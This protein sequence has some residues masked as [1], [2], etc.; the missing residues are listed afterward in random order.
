VARNKS[1]GLLV[2]IPMKPLADAKSR[3]SP[4]IPSS[5]R[6]AAT[7]LMLRRVIRAVENSIGLD[8]KC[9]IIGGDSVVASLVRLIGAVWTEEKGQDLN[10]SLWL[11]MQDAFLYGAKAVLFLPAD[12]PQIN[13]DD[14]TAV[15]DGSDALKFPVIVAA[16]S[17]GGTNTI[18]LPVGSSFP[19]LLG[20]D[21]FAIHCEI[22]NKRGTPFKIM[23]P[24]GLLFDVDSADDLNWAVDNLVDFAEELALWLSWYGKQPMVDGIE[25]NTGLAWLKNR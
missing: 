1:L 8:G 14:I 19:P 17:D 13:S 24:P 20:D 10:S 9:V 4:E 11:A 25:E 22:A 18:L 21:S 12:L 16:G 5:I 23:T 15:V 6:G 2:T 7:L 3:L